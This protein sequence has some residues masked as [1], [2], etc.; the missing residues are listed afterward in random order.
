MNRVKSPDKT[1]RRTVAVT[2]TVMLIFYGLVLLNHYFS[3]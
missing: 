1:L 2:T 3:F